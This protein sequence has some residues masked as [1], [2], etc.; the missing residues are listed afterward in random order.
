MTEMYALGTFNRDGGPRW[1]GVVRD[2]KVAALQDILPDC[3]ATLLDIFENW[4]RLSLAIDNAVARAPGDAWRDE[5]LFVAHLPLK[6]E[7]LFGAGANYRNHVIELVVDSGAGGFQDLSREERRERA[8]REMDERAASGMPFIWVGLRSGIAGPAR[9]LTIPY[10]M[11]Q[12]DWELELAVVIGKSA[13]RVSREDALDYVAGYTI[14]NDI[15]ARELVSRPD[16]KALGMDWLACKSA[17]GFHI[18]GPYITPARFVSDP[19]KLHIRL[20][21]NGEVKQDEGTSDMI[22]DV[23]RLV[24]FA[25]SYAQLQPGDIIMTGSP[26]GNGTHY[27]RFLRDG[28]VMVGEIE[29]I[30]GK[31]VIRCSAE[32]P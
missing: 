2:G 17:P 11:E 24:E 32:A 1:P 4:E 26:S 31:Q 8:T 6:P 23:A 3:P 30:L 15:T 5:D 14:A 10:D 29:G 22:F 13:R 27:N 18:L 25:S 9:G 16:L 28:D 7:N 19:Q 12:V 21:L 20:S